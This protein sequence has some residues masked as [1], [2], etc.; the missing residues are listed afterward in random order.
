[1]PEL[2]TLPEDIYYILDPD[3]DHEVNEENL[4]AFAENLKDLIRTRLR[5]SQYRSDTIRFSGLGK[6]DRQ[7]WYDAHPEGPKE[8]LVPKTYL[9][10]LYGDVIEQLIILLAKEAGHK[11]E[12]EQREVEVDGV[13]GHIDCVID[14]V[15][16]D[17]KSA[18]PYSYKKFENNTVVQD[19]PFGYVEQ[20]AGYATVLTPGKDAAWVANDK[21]GG[22]ICVSRLPSN[23]IKHYPPEDRIRHLKKVI[24]NET[25]P[26]RCY[27]PEPDGKSGNYKLPTG[28]SYCSHKFRCYPNL[29][30]FLYSNGPRFLTTV[31]KTPDVPEVEPNVHE[32]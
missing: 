18:A 9:K 17:V 11:V 32:G 21:V 10:F 20:L 25:P 26:E 27:E 29:R 31:A 13:K 7:I 22:D 2:K 15:V 1:M 6:P 19:N 12:D 8:K 28:C 4:S 14:D 24:E 23:V 16:V 5:K 3:N 30:V